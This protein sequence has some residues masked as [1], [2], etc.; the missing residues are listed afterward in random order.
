MFLTTRLIL[1]LE[2]LGR[3][4]QSFSY[5]AVPDNAARAKQPHSVQR[6]H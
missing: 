5:P 6:K 1:L 2:F 3:K 4:D